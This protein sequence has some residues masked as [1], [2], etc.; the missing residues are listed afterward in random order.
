MRPVASM[1]CEIVKLGN[2]MTA[3]V[4]GRGRKRPKPCSCCG[5]PSTRLCDFVVVP[6]HN[7]VRPQVCDKPLCDACAVRGGKNI[8]YCPDHPK[9]AGAQLGMEG[10]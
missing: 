7:H 2:G 4:C 8:D 9:P 3:I 5:E 10:L 6:A 1:T